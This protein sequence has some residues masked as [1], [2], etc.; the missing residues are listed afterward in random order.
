M[1]LKGVKISINTVSKT[2]NFLDPPTQFF[3]DVIYGWSL[4]GVFQ[5]EKKIETEKN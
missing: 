3:A 5:Q 2:G 1:F 4:V